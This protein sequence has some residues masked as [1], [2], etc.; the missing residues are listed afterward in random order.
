MYKPKKINL[1][2]ALDIGFIILSTDANIGRLKSTSRS[3][4]LNYGK[5]IYRVCITNKKTS[6]AVLKDMKQICSTYRGQNTITSL[7]NSG[8]KKGYKQWN[9]LLMS[10]SWARPRLN[11]KY[12]TFNKSEKDIF[13]P[14][15]PDYNRNDMPIR[16]NNTFPEASLNGLCIHQ[17]TFREVGE[18]SDEEL[19]ISKTWW[20]AN[21]I[22]K[23]CSFKAILGAKIC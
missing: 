15:A 12:A 1:P 22:V 21:A 16:L 14:I 2:I 10:G 19:N 4:D 8:M 9:I 11:E 18:F 7:I 5:E 3:I 17:S 20:M 23:N 13:F 6:S